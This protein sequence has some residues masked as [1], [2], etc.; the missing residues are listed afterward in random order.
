M[1]EQEMVRLV[2]VRAGLSTAGEAR[3][4]LEAALGALRCALD[5]EDARTTARAL[6]HGLSRPLER[7]AST[8]ART[9]GD[10]YAEAQRRERVALGFAMEHAQVV[11]Q[12]L[13]Q[14]LEPELVTLLRKRLPADVAALLEPP[15]RRRRSRRPT[16][17]RVPSISRRP[18]RRSRALARARPRPSPRRA[19]SS[20]TRARSRVRRRPTRTGWWRPPGRPGR[21]E[22]T[23]RSR[24]RAVASAT[25]DPPRRVIR[26]HDTRTPRRRRPARLEPPA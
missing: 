19:T 26:S 21:D 1:Q 4:A 8:T 17:T 11:L 18:C 15:P 9:A 5:D 3:R 25:A 22:R 7:R 23:R 16:S 12:V 13:A 6:P 10:L 14:E 2:K 24:P 20:P